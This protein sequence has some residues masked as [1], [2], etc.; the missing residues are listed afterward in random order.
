MCWCSH[1][2]SALAGWSMFVGNIDDIHMLP[3]LSPSLPHLRQGGNASSPLSINHLF[4]ALASTP[5]FQSTRSHHWMLLFKFLP[6]NNNYI[7][8]KPSFLPMCLFSFLEE[9]TVKTWRVELV[10]AR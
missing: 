3:T 7:I 1:Y 5:L 6:F 4:S 2:M 10:L 8:K 9:M